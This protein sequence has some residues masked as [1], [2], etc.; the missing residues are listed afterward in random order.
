MK[1]NTKSVLTFFNFKDF[2]MKTYINQIQRILPIIL[3]FCIYSCSNQMKNKS[4]QKQDMSEN[5]FTK[6]GAKKRNAQTKY[7]VDNKEVF[8]DTYEKDGR[9]FFCYNNVYN[10]MEKQS[11][12]NFIFRRRSQQEMNI[13]FSKYTDFNNSNN[14][15]AFNP[16]VHQ[17]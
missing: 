3:I 2:K 15:N 17:G 14:T 13:F 16:G 9:Y 8:V 6:I 5:M 7:S 10:E 4:M 1:I 12:G 11:D